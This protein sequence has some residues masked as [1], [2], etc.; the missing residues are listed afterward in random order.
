MIKPLQYIIDP[1]KVI[2]DDKLEF[3]Y[4]LYLPF[5]L[6]SWGFWLT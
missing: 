2:K 1:F 4:G 3:L 5:L 6:A